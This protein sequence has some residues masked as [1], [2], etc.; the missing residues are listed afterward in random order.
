MHSI[1]EWFRL[2]AFIFL[3]WL[4]IT[5]PITFIA[6]FCVYIMADSARRT[7]SAKPFAWAIGVLTFAWSVWGCMALIQAK[8]GEGDEIASLVFLL[9]LVTIPF[10]LFFMVKGIR[11][12]LRFGFRKY[13]GE[14]Q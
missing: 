11:T 10:L 12:L 8:N 7:G 9:I 4:P 3:A 2:G 1:I 6:C 5:L 14:T 13:R